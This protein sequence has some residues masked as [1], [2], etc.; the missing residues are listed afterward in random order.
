MVASSTRGKHFPVFLSVLLLT[1]TPAAAQKF[2]PD[3]PL[4]KELTPLETPDP[5]HRSLSPVLE[6]F[7]NTFTT[8]GEEHPESGVI[9]ALGIN[10]MDEVMDGAWFVNRHS[11]RRLTPT[12]LQRGPGD[13]DLPSRT[14]Q[15]DVLAVKR[16]GYRPGMLMEDDQ[17]RQYFLRFDPPGQ[18]ELSTGAEMVSSKL[19]YA[20]GYWTT[21]NYLLY[22]DRAQLRAASQGADI[23]SMGETRDLL[24]EDIDWFLE[25]V[26]IDPRRG[27]RAVAT[28][29][30]AGVPLGPIQ[31]YT[32]RADD[33][34]DLFAHEHLRVLR[35]LFVFSSWINHTE[36]AAPATLDVLVE[37]DFDSGKI[38]HIR[39]YLIDFFLSLGSGT[40]REKEVREGNDALFSMDSTAR[41]FGHFGIYTPSWM[42]ATFPDLDSVGRF[43][44][45]TFEPAA[46]QPT[47]EPMP[48]R[49]RLP[50]DA[51]WA[52]KILMS[53]N[54]EDIRTVV[55]TGQYSNP[56]AE[57]WIADSLIERRDRI[58]RHYL[59]KLL[60]V[61]EFRIENN[62]LK[63]TNL[64]VRYGFENPHR[65]E[66][67]WSS[68]DNIQESS[69]QIPGASGTALP[70]AV[71]SA[72]AGSYSRAEIVGEGA[73]NRTLVYIRTEPDGA[74]V[75]GVERE[76]PG[77][78]IAQP[79][80]RSLD[81]SKS[82]YTKLTE[83]Q[84]ALFGEFAREYTAE[85]GLQLT[86]GAYWTSLSISERT[87]FTAVTN[88]LENTDLTDEE[89][90]P[91]GT[92]LD[93]VISVQRIAGQ[94]YGRGGDEQFRVYFDIRPD[95]QEILEK[96]RE[97][98]RDKDNTVYHIGYPTSY[99]QAGKPPTMQFSMSEDGTRADVD[100]DYRSS[101]MPS[102]MWNGHI[103]SSNSDVRAGNNYD[104]HSR[105]WSGLAAWWQ[106]LFGD[107]E[108]DES[109]ILDLLSYKA[110]PDPVE[111]PPDRPI[112]FSPEKVTDAAQ[113][114]LS[115]WLGRGQYDQALDFMSDQA[116]AC[117]RKDG[118]VEIEVKK[119]S[120]AARA[121][122]HVFKKVYEKLEGVENPS[123]AIRGKEPW[124]K[125]VYTIIDH[126]YRQFFAAFA[127][128]DEN[129]GR[130]LCEPVSA[131]ADSV[132]QA[133]GR[134][135]PGTYH[136]TMFQF[137][138]GKNGG[139]LALIWAKEGGRWMIVSWVVERQ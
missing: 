39:H 83:T 30:P 26:P 101:K 40:G 81:P 25:G 118:D 131:L 2:F 42:K 35:G 11:R 106:G 15:W 58:G 138:F 75:V 82:H 88:A 94:Y 72:P 17:E 24:E 43:E 127:A 6:Y 4:E 137:R 60:P 109:A 48:F 99:R 111:I 117:V 103:T 86:P 68:F 52:A 105:R 29:V 100:V 51:F 20:L 96:S 139:T 71:R 128:P 116:L 62:E 93:R 84:K 78:T 37:E 69:R 65:F 104:I 70:D 120:D 57:Q 27:Y 38:R 135:E 13:E 54:D 97:F 115:D 66:I 107:L 47:Y 22:F 50:D 5:R 136:A 125:D 32:T 121:L 9:P 19:I 53:M 113:E 14:S 89:G 76:W 73:S 31:F 85:T 87:T 129:A 63:F 41:N 7:S 23:T 133:R 67:F 28:R 123:E 64:A 12:E 98:F 130:Y 8:P 1:G 44:A 126:P 36:A 16:F 74:R 90:N 108:R 61:D 114:F 49:N 45:Q 95:T 119:R 77:K 91:L 79:A 102:S 122:R 124:Q 18:L 55:K 110:P 80:S 134:T 33:P 59:T 10:T 132:R 46:W 56:E 112:G 3:D 92:A 21:E 34:N